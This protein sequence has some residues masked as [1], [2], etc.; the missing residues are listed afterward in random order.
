MFKNDFNKKSK[1]IMLFITNYQ[2]DKNF[3]SR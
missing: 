3:Y 2:N 1:G